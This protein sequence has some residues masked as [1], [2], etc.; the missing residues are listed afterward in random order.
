MSLPP[1]LRNEIYKFLLVCEEPID[2]WVGGY[3]LTPNLLATNTTILH[4]ARS[5]LYGHNHFE[6]IAW[7]PEFIPQFL[8]IIG[9]VNASHVQCIHVGFP[10]LRYLE[11][12]VSLEDDSLH[13]LEN[14][15]S[16][17]TNLKTLIISSQSMNIIERQLDLVDSPTICAKAFALV[18]ARFKAISSLQ[19]I[20]VE[21]HSE[22]PS[23]DI[24]NKMKSHGWIFRVVEPVEE[25]D[26][27]IDGS[28]YDFEDD[29]YLYDDDDD[30]DYDVDNGSDYWRRQAD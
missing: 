12:D 22:G 18:D 13:I 6:L 8:D 3:W 16:H 21:V 28:E 2:P 24:R 5:I 20:I 9:F 19:E 10:R 30:D 29:E 1:E 26:W 14:I 7:N 25:V 15:K 17:C 11:D 4:E 27:D 23:S